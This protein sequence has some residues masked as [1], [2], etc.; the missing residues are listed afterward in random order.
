M[1]PTVTEL[2]NL[3]LE[4]MGD[5]DEG[6]SPCSVGNAGPEVGVLEIERRRHTLDKAGARWT[7]RNIVVSVAEDVEEKREWLHV[8]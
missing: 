1:P 8:G 4:T 5:W 7:T 2:K 6:R 3:R